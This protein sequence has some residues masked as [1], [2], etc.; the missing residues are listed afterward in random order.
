MARGHQKIQSQKK[1]QEKKDKMKKSGGTS[2]IASAKKAL[3]FT[4]S[5]C[6]VSAMI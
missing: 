1:N 4:C 2:Q 3:I 6:R 5:V